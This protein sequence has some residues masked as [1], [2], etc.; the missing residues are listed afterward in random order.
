MSLQ[1]IENVAHLARQVA[2]PTAD[3]VGCPREPDHGRGHSALTERLVELLRL[4]DR[5]PEVGFSGEEHG[6]GLDLANFG[7]G[8]AAPVGL[9][10]LPGRTPKPIAREERALVGGE[11]EAGPVDDRLGDH[12]CP[13][14][15]R[16][17]DQPGRQ[18]PTA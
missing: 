1:P 6:R 12:R 3:A 13:E 8:R 14:A 7:Q 18:H 10:I 11:R 5:R 17:A 16:H 4:R 2:G 15:I 9:V